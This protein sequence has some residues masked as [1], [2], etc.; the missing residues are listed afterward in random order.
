MSTKDLGLH[1]TGSKKIIFFKCLTHLCAR[2]HAERNRHMDK[3]MNW[4][5]TNCLTPLF[6]KRVHKIL[7]KNLNRNHFKDQF[8]FSNSFTTIYLGNPLTLQTRLLHVLLMH[9]VGAQFDALWQQIGF[10]GYESALHRHPS[11]IYSWFM[12]LPFLLHLGFKF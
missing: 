8:I 5:S 2:K 7:Y 1:C 10:N 11:Y 9:Y 3:K 6:R 4:Q 12:K